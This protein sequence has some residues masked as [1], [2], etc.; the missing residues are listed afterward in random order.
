MP[1]IKYRNVKSR[2]KCSPS[3]H[4]EVNQQTQKAGLL[5]LAILLVKNEFSYSIDE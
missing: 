3:Q 5:N 1:I 2:D 4:T